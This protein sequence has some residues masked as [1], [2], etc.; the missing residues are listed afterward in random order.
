MNSILI[1]ENNLPEPN[2]CRKGGRFK[3]L[4]GQKFGRLTALYPVDK[5]DNKWR[6]LCQCDCKKYVLVRSTYLIS[7]HTQSCGCYKRERMIFGNLNNL[8]GQ[9]FNNIYV[10]EYY[11]S[12]KEHPRYK[13]KCL[14]CN[15]E[16]IVSAD[17]LRNGQKS[18]GCLRSSQEEIVDKILRENQINFKREYTFPDLTG[19]NNN[20]LRFDFA[21]FD[22]NGDIYSLIEI[23]GPQHYKNIYNLSEEDFKESLERDKKKKDYCLKNKYYLNCIDWDENFTLER[24]MYKQL[25]D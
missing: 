18:C 2:N 24:I 8:S 5:T 20:K 13:A 1:E 9:T 15:K 10:I 19:R 23:Q 4:T 16:F 25:E 22:S 11:D 12:K 14:L 7:L 17:A 21:I 3:D 6:W